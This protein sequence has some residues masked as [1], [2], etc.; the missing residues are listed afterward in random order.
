M[1]APRIYLA[2]PDVFDVNAPRKF[3]TLRQWCAERG[4]QGME[5]SDGEMQTRP[6]PGPVI[7]QRIYRANITLLE[8]CQGV[9]ANLVPFRGTEPDSGTVF[10]IGYAVAKGL[11]V[12]CV[13]PRADR[14]YRERVVESCGT[15]ECGR[16]D[17]SQGWLIEDF[18]LPE[19]L[20]LAVSCKICSSEEEALDWLKAQLQGPL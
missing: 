5:P 8:S 3:E 4:L 17:A 9:I 11:P 14:P 10:E 6:G 15:S 7:A 1:T 18:G 12:A 16:Y 20:M 19:N 13:C 2:G